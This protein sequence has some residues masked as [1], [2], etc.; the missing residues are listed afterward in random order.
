MD[1]LATGSCAA[2]ANVSWLIGA[3]CG[4]AI[5]IAVI[6]AI[7]HAPRLREHG[8]T[9]PPSIGASGRALPWFPAALVGVYRLRFLGHRIKAYAAMAAV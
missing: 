9:A 4:A 5:D 7:A 1:W 3:I 8:G 6:A 2:I